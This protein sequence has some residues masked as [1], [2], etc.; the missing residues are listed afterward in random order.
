[1]FCFLRLV[2]LPLKNSLEA[3]AGSLQNFVLPPFL[4]WQ[5]SIQ[6][7]YHHPWSSRRDAGTVP[8]VVQIDL[9]H[10]E[11]KSSDHIPNHKH[12]AWGCT[13]SIALR[14]GS[15]PPF[16]RALMVWFNEATA[17]ACCTR[18]PIHGAEEICLH[19]S[20]PLMWT[21]QSLE[22]VVTHLYETI[23]N[24]YNTTAAQNSSGQLSEDR[25]ADQQGPS[26]VCTLLA[27]PCVCTL[28]SHGISICFWRSPGRQK[29]NTA[30]ECNVLKIT[31]TNFL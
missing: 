13:A 26:V 19:H 14:V 11:D 27:E 5:G 31:I 1:M 18:E 8:E 28:T 6:G 4:G 21:R 17:A 7:C 29:F 12:M 30:A 10:M 9:C 22:H 3:V 15:S 16:W 2:A 23:F 25:Q 24:Y 20:V